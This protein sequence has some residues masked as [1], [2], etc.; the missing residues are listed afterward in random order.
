V[1]RIHDCGFKVLLKILRDSFCWWLLFVW[2]WNLLREKF[3]I[4]K[5]AK[6][7]LNGSEGVLE[8]MK[9]AQATGYEDTPMS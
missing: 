4:R 2:G 6:I 5:F 3:L 8:I 1:R 9:I 7:A